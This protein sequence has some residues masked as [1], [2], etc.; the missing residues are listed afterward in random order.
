[1]EIEAKFAVSD[2]ATFQRLQAVEHVAGFSLSAHQVQ[3]VQDTYLDTEERIILAHGYACRRRETES[4]VLITLKALGRA[5]GAIHR[6]KE[7]EIS[8]PTYASPQEWPDSAVRDLVLKMAA[9]DPLI[10]LFD[11]R[12]TR[13]FRRMR[14]G[15]LLVAQLSL[16]NVRI[17]AN[18]RKKGHFELE[19]ELAPQGTANDMAAIIAYLQDEWN[20]RAEPC[21]K[22]ERALSFLAE[23]EP[24]GDLLRPQERAICLQLSRRSDVYGRRAQGLLLL[25]EGIDPDETARRVDRTGRTVRRWLNSFREEGLAG[26]PHRVLREVQRVTP[27]TLPGIPEQ[28]GELMDLSGSGVAG[29]EQEEGALPGPEP[30]PLKALFKRYV[31]DRAHARQVAS[32][33]QDLFDALRPFHRVA[34]K[35][36]HLVDTA[37]MVHSIGMSPVSGR[38]GKAGH[39][40]LLAHP[41]E[42]LNEAERLM[43]ALTTTLQG[44]QLTWKK[45]SKKVSEDP[46][47]GLSKRSREEALALSALVRMADGLDYSQTQSTRLG[48]VAKKGDVVDIEVTGPYAAM[49]AA[50]AQERSDLWQLL[51][52]VQLGFRPAGV[53]LEL[54]PYPGDARSR[55]LT[56]DLTPEQ[57]PERPSLSADD[58]MG[59]AAC[60][61]VSFHFQRMLYHEP[62]TREGEDIEE[63]HD[64]RVATRRMQAAF[65]VFGPYVDGRRLKSMRKGARRTRSKLG[66]VRDLDIFW[67]KTERYLKGLPP[68]RQNDLMPL[69]EAW[70]AEREQAREAMLA[71]LDS[72]SYARFKERSL[73]LLNTP[74][75]WE[76]RALTDKGEA[77]PHRVRH[78]VPAAVYEQAAAILA[79]DEWVNGPD[80]SLKRLHRL[81]IAGKQLRYTLEFF[82]PVLAP[83]TADLI[84]QMKRLQDHLGDLQDAVVASELLRDF[85]TWG[86]WGHA[87]DKLESKGRRE[88][89]VVPDVAVY[90]ADKQAELQKLIDGFP[91]VWAAFQGP[92]FRQMVAVVVA[93]L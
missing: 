74:E 93:P 24:G 41:P 81:R 9:G 4:E 27:A 2:V 12:Q 3:Q 58:T 39:D 62:G 40:L 70:E 86:A 60:K 28:Q 32:H 29:G 42:E 16:D 77:V 44:K 71:Y 56:I 55:D 10:P 53:A 59:E 84:K 33:A 87:K 88:P 72:G 61:T 63:L 91:K 6:R 57:L 13:V 69:K 73:A 89:I 80:I 38:P 67:E 1:M 14:Q 5:E 68:E 20:L 11:L 52:G 35:H 78:V 19:V 85:V 34:S 45:V 49:D 43:V 30:Q 75:A 8:L 92:E 37:A 64:M 66:S 83:Q 7:L 90:L 22:F 21:S 46:F 36:R 26:F 23:E 15:E 31:T 50:R 76:L 65:R 25:D 17:I 51:F 79:Y 54:T 82:K 48:P 18:R 47:G